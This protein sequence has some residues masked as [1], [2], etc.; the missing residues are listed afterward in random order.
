M[1]VGDRPGD[2]WAKRWSEKMT[3]RLPTAGAPCL[4]TGSWKRGQAG[5]LHSV[6]SNERGKDSG[7]ETENPRRFVS[8]HCGCGGLTG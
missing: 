4:D 6:V 7:E 5:F 1:L 8:F 3:S 2:G